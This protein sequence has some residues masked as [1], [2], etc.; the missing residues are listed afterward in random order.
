MVTLQFRNGYPAPI[1]FLL[2]GEDTLLFVPVN[3]IVD[4]RY[5]GLTVVEADDG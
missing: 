4:A 5:I 3:Q 1:H 2:G